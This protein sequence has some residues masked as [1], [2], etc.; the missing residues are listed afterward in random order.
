MAIVLKSKKYSEMI[1]DSNKIIGVMGNDYE[2]F[3][4]SLKGENIFVVNKEKAF[5]EKTGFDELNII[6]EKSGKK[7]ETNELIE[8]FLKELK[9]NNYLNKNI[10]ELSN[11]E[12]RLLDY[13]CMLISNPNIIVID[14][15]FLNFDY[16]MKKKITTLLKQ[17][18]KSS[19]KTIIIGSRDSNV[20]YSLC[21]KVLLFKDDEYYYGNIDDLEKKDILKKYDI[22]IP[23]LVE[24][25]NLAHQKKAILPY[26]KDIRDLIKDVYR[27]VQKKGN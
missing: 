18:V 20:I 21:Q 25:V 22:N 19:H 2:N 27:N 1:I 12:L 5:K 13:L 10:N 16:E 24:F 14:E 9:I 11:S 17:I 4:K 3:L 6:N 15:P 26:S 8:L 7:K 23:D